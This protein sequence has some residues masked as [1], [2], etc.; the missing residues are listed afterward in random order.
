MQSPT[1][2]TQ[3]SNIAENGSV[4]ANTP[5]EII[6]QTLPL[7]DRARFEAALAK[8]TR[9]LEEYASLKSATQR[10]L[11][12]K[13]IRHELTNGH[14]LISRIEQ[15]MADAEH[16]AVRDYVLT[17]IGDGRRRRPQ[18]EGPWRVWKT[19][20]ADLREW[21]SWVKAALPRVKSDRGKPEN[22]PLKQL[23]RDLAKIW[24]DFTAKPFTG[25]RKSGQRPR[26]FVSAIC[27]MIEPDLT[28]AQI[29]TAIKYAVRKLPG[30]RRGR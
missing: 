17:A 2:E 29:E 1:S 22:F 12:T 18:T 20:I 23:V 7:A 9:A 14:S 8:I 5:K 16:S 25:T 3:L 21:R 26:D 11:T 19:Q 4:R 6:E 15:W 30:T 28:G 27:R 10:Q 13:Q 24:D